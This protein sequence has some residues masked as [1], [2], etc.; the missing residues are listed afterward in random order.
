MKKEALFPLKITAALA[1]LAAV[2]IIC[3]K[4]LAIRGGDILRFSFENLPIIFAGISFGPIAGVL[5][6]V[7]AD[8]VGCVMVGYTVNPLVT[9][10]AAAIGAFSGISAIIF[11]K[12]GIKGAAN[13]VISVAIAHIFGSVLIKTFG[14]S[15][16]YD[17]P[18]W[19][20]M[21]WRLLNYVIVGALEAALLVVLLKNKGVT[22]LISDMKPRKIEESK[23]DELHKSS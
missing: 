18:L 7:V 6:G 21:L 22:R 9:L 1:M 17:L 14:L 20:L 5:V 3:G 12:I 23:R 15:A 13:T 8:L 11:K 19:A 10:G 16:Y 2:S 4:Y